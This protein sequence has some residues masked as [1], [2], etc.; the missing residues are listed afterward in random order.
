MPTY[1]VLVNWTERGIQSFQDSPSRAD[2]VTQLAERLGGSVKDLYWTIGPHDI[3]GT[4]EAPDD[5][6]MTAI[7]LAIGSQGNVRT[8]TLRAFDRQEI[9]GVIGK[10]SGAQ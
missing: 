10:A 8:T 5:E 6:T 7:A 1:V 4:F 3:V 2:A 9:E